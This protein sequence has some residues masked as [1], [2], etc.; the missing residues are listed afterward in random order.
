MSIIVD[1]MTSEAIRLSSIADDMAERL[2]DMRR[3][4][5]TAADAGCPGPSAADILRAERLAKGARAAADGALRAARRANGE[6]PFPRSRWV[7]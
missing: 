4:A 2:A 5:E 6:R 1:Y 3:R 7:A